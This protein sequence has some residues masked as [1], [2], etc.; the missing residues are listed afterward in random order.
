VTYLVLDEADRMLDMGFEPQVRQVVQHFDMDKDKRQTLM[1]S[2]TFA[3]DIQQ[4]AM[5]FLN[6]YI[7]L[8]VGRVGSTTDMIHQ[9]YIIMVIRV[10]IRV[11]GVIAGIYVLYM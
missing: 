6:N 8:A 3:K 10:I 2:A 11:V 4:L 1:F 9:V 5:E 7:F